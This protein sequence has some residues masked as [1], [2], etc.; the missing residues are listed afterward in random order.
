MTDLSKE[1]I[2][3]LH[4]FVHLL[5]PNAAMHIAT[6]QEIE[7]RNKRRKLKDRIINSVI[8]ILCVLTLFVAWLTYIKS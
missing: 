8:P 7:R 5:M 6:I 2:K 4:Q 3:K 1:P